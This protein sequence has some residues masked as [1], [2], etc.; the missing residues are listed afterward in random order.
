MAMVDVVIKKTVSNT[1][2]S[3]NIPVNEEVHYKLYNNAGKLVY[4]KSILL[5]N[6]DSKTN[7]DLDLSHLPPGNYELNVLLGETGNRLEKIKITI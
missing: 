7:E 2:L 1:V 4:S 5:L 6:T 3:R